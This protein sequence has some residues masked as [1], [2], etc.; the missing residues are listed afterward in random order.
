MAILHA[1]A[2]LRPSKLEALTTWLPTRSW[3]RGAVTPELTRVAGYRFDDPDGEVGM[4]TMLVRAGDGPVYQIPLTYRGAPL[5]GREEFLVGTSDHSAL[6]PRWFYDACGDPLYARVLS[7]VILTGAGEADEIALID[8]REERRQ[9]SMTVRGSGTAGTPAP[10]VDAIVRV[11]DGDPTL[12]VADGVELSIRR[13]LDSLVLDSPGG[14]GHGV[15]TG[16]WKGQTSPVVLV[17]LK[18]V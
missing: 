12:V 3:Y 17:G 1:Q 9:P 11:S 16:T 7:T 8:G 2:T 10:S 5:E 13:V 6:G 15:L 14:A 18:S 4:E